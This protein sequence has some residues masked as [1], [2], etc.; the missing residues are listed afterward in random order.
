MNVGAGVLARAES[1]I[2]VWPWRRRES[3]SEDARAYM[4]WHRSFAQDDKVGRW[5]LIRKSYGEAV[6]P[7]ICLVGLM[8]LDKFLLMKI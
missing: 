2:E 8:I 5:T 7:N 3:T 1:G 4:C 6:D